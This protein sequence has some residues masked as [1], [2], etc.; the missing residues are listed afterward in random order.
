MNYYRLRRCAFACAALVAVIAG[1]GC[2][3]S[4]SS[5]STTAPPLSVALTLVPTAGTLDAVNPDSLLYEIIPAS[6][7]IV[8]PAS[9]KV[10]ISP[11]VLFTEVNGFS[12]GTFANSIDIIPSGFLPQATAF[13][14]TTNFLVVQNNTVYSVTAY[15]SFTTAAVTAAFPASAG[16]SYLLN[17]NTL[18]QPPGLMSL[19]PG[20]LPEI[21]A[22]IL[23]ATVSS[24]PS[25]AGADGSFLLYGGQAFSSSSP[26]DIDPSAFSL[27][28]IA[29]YQRN[30]FIASGAAA[31]SVSGFTIT[32]QSLSLRGTLNTDGTVSGGVFYGLIHCTDAACSNITDTAIASAVSP[33]VDTNGNMAVIGTFTGTAN[34]FSPVAWIGA[35]DTA[36][37]TLAN[38]IGAGISTVTLDITSTSSSLTTTATLPYVILTQTDAN[39]MLS[40]SAQGQGAVSITTTAPQVSIDYPL[41]EPGLSM[42]PFTTSAGQTYSA[43]FM[44]GLTNFTSITFTP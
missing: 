16:D 27:P 25:A 41:V 11:S 20:T 29:S 15:N 19:I 9:V 2:G 38:G 5:S 6:A 34:I 18:I 32:F 13:S 28:V 35:G 23:T 40:L 42:T 8:D 17:I 26:T 3:S 12:G 4:S 14:I 33:Y 22:S 39:N 31:V 43:Y 10:S 36:T 1:F 30:E 24:N 37:T 21:A 7:G 44:F